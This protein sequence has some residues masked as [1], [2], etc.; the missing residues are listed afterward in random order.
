MK[1]KYKDTIF[2]DASRFGSSTQ[3]YDYIMLNRLESFLL[4]PIIPSIRVGHCPCGQYLQVK[5]NVILISADIQSTVE[6]ILPQEQ[7]LFPVS[8]KRKI[9]YEG[10]YLHEI[11]D[12]NKVV[13]YFEWLRRNNPHFFDIVLKEEE[14]DQ[15]SFD[16][17]SQAEEFENL[18]QPQMVEPEDEILKEE[19][20]EEVPLSSQ[21]VSAMMNKYEGDNN[22]RSVTNHIADMII[23]FE[24]DMGIADDEF[25]DEDDDQIPEEESSAIKGSNKGKV[26]VAPGKF[27]KFVRY[28]HS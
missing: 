3:Q 27:G 26:C 20:S 12:K 15:F 1:C 5:G 22:D 8:F 19:I 25:Q 9:I 6:K 2:S 10:Y 14:I 18:S 13:S 17:K 21:Y 24:K 11:I 28:S 23:E 16:M 4:K 7:H